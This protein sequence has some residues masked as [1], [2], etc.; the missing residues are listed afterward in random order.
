MRLKPEKIAQ[1]AELIY[2]TLAKNEGLKL[3]GKREDVTYVIRDVIITDLK[4]E[5]EIEAEAKAILEKHENEIRR[6]NVNYEQ[7]FRK[8]KDKLARDRGMV[9]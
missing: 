8:T 4:T 9:L 5:D 3:E 2:D 6:G 1:L 7:I